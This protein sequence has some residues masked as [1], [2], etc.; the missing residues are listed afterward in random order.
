M[1]KT[2]KAQ[3]MLSFYLDNIGKWS[4]AIC[5]CENSKS[6]QTAALN[7]ELRKQ[8][9]EFE[10]ISPN[11]NQWAKQIYCEK[12][13]DITSHYKLLSSTPNP[14]NIK[15]R[16]PIPPKIRK[17]IIDLLNNKD[18]FTGATITSKPETDHKIPWTR[19]TVDY[20]VS[21]MSDEE[22]KNAYQLLTREHNLLKD[23][24]CDYC[25]KNNIRPPFL[26]I[27]FWYQGDENYQG[28]CEGCG[29]YDGVKWRKKVN[30]ILTKK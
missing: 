15:E 9:Y 22:L 8:G 16:I 25:K 1:R 5:S 29:W 23:R 3:E 10:E 20:D 12:C 11:S 24:R 19:L 27:S 17:H 4:C 6:S 30:E 26:G 2:S 21:T 13:G 7:R 18:A 28:T 14:L